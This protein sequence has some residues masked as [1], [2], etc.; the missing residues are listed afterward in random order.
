MA[1]FDQPVCWWGKPPKKQW[2][3]S[4]TQ[5]KWI[6]ESSWLIKKCFST[7]PN[8]RSQLDQMLL[9]GSCHTC[10]KI[11]LAPAEPATFIPSIQSGLKGNADFILHKHPLWAGNFTAG[12]TCLSLLQWHKP[13]YKL[14]VS[15]WMNTKQRMQMRAFSA[16]LGCAG[17]TDSH[18]HARD[19]VIPHQPTKRPK[20][21]REINRG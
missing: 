13:T 9:S 3:P 2:I 10:I 12:E 7:S 19:D 11:W 17:M 1:H 18:T 15:Y 21:T 20:T 4:S 8:D 5:A 6:E 16:H 14:T